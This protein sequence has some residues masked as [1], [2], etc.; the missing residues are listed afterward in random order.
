MGCG[1]CGVGVGC[2]QAKN[3]T[4]Q[5]I[6][7]N[8]VGCYRPQP[9]R[10]CSRRPAAKS[11]NTNEWKIVARVAVLHSER[12]GFAHA[13]LSPP[14]FGLTCPSYFGVRSSKLRSRSRSLKLFGTW[15]GK[16]SLCW[17][18][19]VLRSVWRLS[20]HMSAPGQRWQSAAPR[21]FQ[22]SN[23]DEVNH[24][25]RRESLGG[26]PSQ[27]T[28]ERSEPTGVSVLSGFTSWRYPHVRGEHPRRAS[29]FVGK[30]SMASGE[31][32]VTRGVHAGV[33]SVRACSRQHT[34][35]QEEWAPRAHRTIVFAQ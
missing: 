35:L 30:P 28:C 1:Q 5:N 10:A 20:G 16:G 25:M 33:A 32:E 26:S 34:G 24:P 31:E 6:R 4:W 18:S 29:T 11:T 9:L 12:H 17:T 22:A 7:V 14:G 23:F 15:H 27:S 19:F 13:H 2:G 8:A 3:R 21:C